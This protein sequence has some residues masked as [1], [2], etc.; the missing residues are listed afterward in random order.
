MI[1]VYHLH[2]LC[3]ARVANQD[4]IIPELVDLQQGDGP[5]VSPAD[6]DPDG[7]PFQIGREFTRN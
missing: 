6:R 7:G 4:E 1:D 3:L 2:S 5:G